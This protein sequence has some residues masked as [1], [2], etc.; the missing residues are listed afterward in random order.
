MLIGAQVKK[1]GVSRV[2]YRT[3]ELLEFLLCEVLSNL[4]LCSVNS[5]HLGPPDF[6]T[7]SSKFRPQCPIWGSPLPTMPG[8]SPGNNLGQLRGSS[9]LFPVS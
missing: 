6:S 2:P 3:L 9:Y 8:N 7:L 5:S 1:P 4:A